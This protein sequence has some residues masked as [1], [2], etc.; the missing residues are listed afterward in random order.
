M[1]P[2]SGESPLLLVQITALTGGTA[3]GVLASHGALDADA[4]LL[5]LRNW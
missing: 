4:Q 1:D 5:F 3:L 2:R